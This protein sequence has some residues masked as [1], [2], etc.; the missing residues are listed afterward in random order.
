MLL[1]AY[2]NINS[3]SHIRHQEDTSSPEISIFISTMQELKFL[4]DTRGI[5]ES[6]KKLTVNG[7]SSASSQS[8]PKR[9]WTQRV[10]YPTSE[11]PKSVQ[12]K[13]AARRTRE[14]NERRERNLWSSWTITSFL[15]LWDCMSNCIVKTSM[16]RQFIHQCDVSRKL[17]D[18]DR[19]NWLLLGGII[20]FRLS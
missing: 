3:Q 2:W 8:L 1:H 5:I 7:I 15:S 17:G 4:L 14:R 12:A 13:T 6:L 19:W 20:P 16:E 18:E 11:V 10:L 9:N